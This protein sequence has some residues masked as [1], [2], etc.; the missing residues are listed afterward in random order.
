MSIVDHILNHQVIGERYFFPRSGRPPEAREFV[1]DDG[2]LLCCLE[3]RPHNDARTLV[4]FHGNGEIVTDYLQDYLEAVSALGVNLLMVEYR[5]YGGSGGVPELGKMLQDVHSVR[6][7]CGLASE[8][9]VLYGRSVGAIFA[10]EWVSQA[11]DV[12]GLILESGVA[13]PLQRLLL[14]LEPEEL[15]VDLQTLQSV[16]A[17]RLSHRD[18][19]SQYFG[20]L[21]L[22]HAQ[23]DTLVGPE[24]ARWH[25]QWAVT[26]KKELVLF[27]KGDHNTIL[28]ANWEQY[29]EQLEA[30]FQGTAE[31]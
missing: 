26:Q 15:G 27:S 30:F 29:L 13:D 10:V 4:H 2:T 31:R 22:L 23:G 17:Q 19:L 16:C 25:H 20:P 9:V 5:G 8:Q 11:P 21:L 3:H 12:A 28:A 7:Q 6:H 18:K 1:A 24:H 14:R